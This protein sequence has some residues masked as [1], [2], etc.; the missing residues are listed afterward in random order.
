AARLAAAES[1]L[2]RTFARLARVD[3]DRLDPE[4]PLTAFGLDSLVA[5]ELK[6]AL[7]TELTVS[8]S[9]AAF[10]DGMSLSEAARR[11]LALVAAGPKPALQ[12][13][14]AAEVGEHPLSWGQRSLW[15]VYRLAPE[16]AAYNMPSLLRLPAAADVDA[17][18][19][20]F[21]ALTDRHPVL[22][23]TYRDGPD[24]PVQTVV[25]RIESP[26]V[27]IDAT[28]WSEA[29]LR[30][31]VEEEAFRP[32]DLER[33]PVLRALLF[34]RG[35]DREPLLLVCLHHIAADLWSFAVL[36]REMGTLYAAFSGGAAGAVVELPRLALR[37]ADY[38]RWQEKMLAGPD[39]QRLWEYWRD[40]LSGVPALELPVDRQ[41]PA[42]P[43][44]HGA[45][46]TVRL[47][48]ALSGGLRGLARS[49]GCTLFMALLAGFQALLS[50]L[51]GQEDFLVGCPTFGRT[52]GNLGNRLAGQIGY[53]VNPVALRADLSGEPAVGEWLRR[54]HRAA[55]DAFEH[56]DFPLALLAERLQPE[57]GAGAPLI[58]AMLVLQRSPFPEL[59][60]VVALSLSESGTRL[61][62]PGLTLESVELENPTTQ[63]D[64]GLTAGEVGDGIVAQ[65]RF[66][67]ELFDDATAERMLDHL[68]NFLRGMVADAGRPVAE[69]E[70]LSASEHRQLAAWNR[71]AVARPGGLCLHRL[72]EQQAER[73]P[74]AVALV[75]RS[76]Q[77]SY[78]ELNRRA[79]RLAHHL[80]RQG[81]APEI[82]V[83]VLLGR[84]PEMVASLL[85][86]LKAGGAYV[87]LDSSYPVERLAFMAGDAE[88]GVLLT[89]ARTAALST[90]LALPAGRT[91]QIDAAA[92]ERERADDPLPTAGP[93]NLAYVLYTS[94]STGRPKGVAV[95]HRSPVELAHWAGDAF[96]AAELAGVLAATS[97]CFDLS[98]FELFVPLCHGGTVVLA[99]NALELPTLP[100]AGRVTLINTVPSAM[101][102]LAEGV[103]P[104]GL[105]TINLAGEP[106]Q[107][108]LVR[109]LHR[110]P[111]V[112]RVLNLY[113]P[114]EDTTYS[115]CEET[116]RDAGRVTLG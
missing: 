111:Q 100:A 110:H 82:P 16:S 12:P 3:P 21:Q 70:L 62:L 1:F 37:Y 60:A 116:A 54:V 85:G 46:R 42:V 92:G 55:L 48:A 58:Q 75:R 64:I 4:Q 79:N 47:D 77:L 67:T 88:I 86:V 29:E 40:R 115:T 6:G 98:I 9:V 65:L 38:A 73:T 39:G 101:A 57:R 53:F 68:G 81:V 18:R 102:Q 104:P 113:G 7:E 36:A 63:F 19:R 26:L 61:D 59:A 107:P 49:W 11:V 95:E 80:R 28:G 5:I 35:V 106:L 97:I 22:R 24:G 105:C 112:R 103:L 52:P 90:L 83:G 66:S 89:D 93:T 108:D 84:S 71:T 31:R 23:T 41:R 20:A 17:F 27:Y 25:E 32:F 33:G 30:R 114:S 2:R 76:E 45:A 87:P 34:A 44:Y 94:G 10:L 99:E 91:V 50:R 13:M 69:L 109:R 78:G 15:F 96:S 72:F 8:P 56:E 51:G 43:T 14:A 74:E